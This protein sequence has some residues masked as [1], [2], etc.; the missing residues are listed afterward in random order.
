MKLFGSLGPYKWYYTADLNRWICLYVVQSLNRG[1]AQS[2][3]SVSISIVASNDLFAS[4][5]QPA[6]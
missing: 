1:R 4:V 3:D 6:L 5:L 2:L